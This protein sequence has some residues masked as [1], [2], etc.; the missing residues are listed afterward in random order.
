MTSNNEAEYAALHLGLK[1][2]ELLGVHHMKV[3]ILG[4]SLV[5]MKQLTDEWPVYDKQLERWL[6]RIEET[7]EALGLIPDY[8]PISRQQNKEADQ[9]ATQALQGIDIMSQKVLD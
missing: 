6:D 3:T 1:E 5:V 8:Q 2:L 9:L 7:I 4:D